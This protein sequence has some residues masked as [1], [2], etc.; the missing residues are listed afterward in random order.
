MKTIFILIVMLIQSDLC[1]S[2]WTF[3]YSGTSADLFDVLYV[4]ETD[5][6]VVGGK[7]GDEY[8][9][10]LKTTNGGQAWDSIY[11]GTHLLRGIAFTSINTGYV[12]G[13]TGTILRTTDGGNNWTRL[14]SGTT[15]HLRSVSFPPS[16]TGFTGFVCGFNGMMLKT[17][18]AGASWNIQPT[19]ITKVLF[20]IHSYDANICFAVGGDNS[21]GDQ[22]VIIR[23]TN[24]GIN[25]IQQTSPMPSALRGIF[26]KDAFN[27]FAAGNDN[28]LIRTSNGGTNWNNVQIPGSRF[29]RDIYF[30]DSSDGYVCGNFGCILSTTNGGSSWDT[31][32][33]LTQ[34]Y[35][36]AI[37]FLNKNTGSAVGHS[38][39]ILKYSVMTGVSNSNSIAYTF[40][41]DQNYPNPFNPTTVINF[42]LKTEALVELKVFDVRGNEVHTLINEARQPGNYDVRFEGA[43]FPSGVYYYRLT[44]RSFGGKVIES[45][46]RAMILLK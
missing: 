4:S 12:V 41:M 10:I 9:I 39:T 2:G 36:E 5:G 14:N 17:V 28:V 24:G 29:L 33:S 38:G 3:Q 32:A 30:I 20:S 11:G 31:T 22:P 15:E 18:T 7:V 42:Q 35:L 45:S 8:G 27:A 43:E 6:Y 21:L 23:T 25:W 44:T 1:Y 19:G 40:L 26:M 16:G 13:N 46:A 34:R 37:S